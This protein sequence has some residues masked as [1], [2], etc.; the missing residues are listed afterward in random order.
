M[1]FNLLRARI[2]HNF[3]C[4]RKTSFPYKPKAAAKCMAFPIG[5]CSPYMRH[6]EYKE[7]LNL[8]LGAKADLTMMEL[9]PKIKVKL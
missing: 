1:F 4:R 6:Y 9:A 7:A 2:I 8:I 5:N 3:T